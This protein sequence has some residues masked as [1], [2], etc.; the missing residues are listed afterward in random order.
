MILMG[1]NRQVEI[2]PT[3]TVQLNPPWREIATMRGR[4]AQRAHGPFS[5]RIR[6]LRLQ[7]PGLT[8]EQL[9]ERLHMTTS[10]V[11]KLERGDVRLT[12]DKI[13]ALVSALGCHPLELYTPLSVEEREALI[14][15]RQAPPAVRTKLLA[16]M[17]SALEMSEPAIAQRRRA[18]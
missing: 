16:L 2:D 10:A 15:V 11:G 17:R 7:V 18:S 12:S 5:N 14:L 9:A 1:S 8:Q 3:A 13:P 6:E 4:P